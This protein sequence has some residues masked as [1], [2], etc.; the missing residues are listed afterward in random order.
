MVSGVQSVS[1]VHAGAISR[2]HIARKKFADDIVRTLWPRVRQIAGELA[3]NG[4]L[5]IAQDG[6]ALDVLSDCALRAVLSQHYGGP[7]GSFSLLVHNMLQS[8]D[9][10]PYW[11]DD[12]VARMAPFDY[13]GEAG[14]RQ[15]QEYKLVI[16]A[17]ARTLGEYFPLKNNELPSK[18]E[19][20]A[21]E[22]ALAEY[23]ESNR[24]IDICP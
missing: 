1:Q 14:E 17:A 13:S 9:R 21:A 24:V 5:P 20:R 6:Q 12:R 19:L 7:P 2:L 4:S 22:K 16:Q 8:Q 10:H 15:R 18:E 3:S 11:G 23:E